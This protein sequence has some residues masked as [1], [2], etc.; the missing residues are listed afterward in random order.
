MANCPCAL[1]DESTTS[2]KFY[3]NIHFVSF[4]R[5]KTNVVLLW[6]WIKNAFLSVEYRGSS[7]F[8]GVATHQ[9]HDQ[10]TQHT[11]GWCVEYPGARAHFY[12]PRWDAS[13][14]FYSMLL[15]CMC[16]VST[17]SS[18]VCVVV[19]LQ[20][21]CLLPNLSKVGKS[22]KITIQFQF[23]ISDPQSPMSTF[24]RESHFVFMETTS[25]FCKTG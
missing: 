16:F 9:V 11:A 25:H 14:C 22:A 19:L 21:T 5:R 2:D 12:L 23:L 13:L 24:P 4:G 17:C 3:I 1:L 7:A 10:V 18:S 20:I 15:S 8:Q 6:K